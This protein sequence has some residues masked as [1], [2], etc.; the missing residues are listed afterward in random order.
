MEKVGR[1]IHG[2]GQTWPFVTGSQINCLEWHF[3][4]WKANSMHAGMTPLCHP[5]QP[6]LIDHKCSFLLSQTWSWIHIP[7][8][9]YQLDQ[10]AHEMNLFVILALIYVLKSVS[11]LYLLTVRLETSGILYIQ[12]SMI[13]IVVIVNICPSYGPSILHAWN[14]LILTTTWSY[15]QSCIT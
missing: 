15:L 4:L 6:S 13:T 9:C 5:K 2:Q 14:H 10:L 7:G 8:S 3:S 11:H 12:L 1:G